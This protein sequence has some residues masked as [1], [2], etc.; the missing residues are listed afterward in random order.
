[1]FNIFLISNII[2]NISNIIALKKSFNR[3]PQKVTQNYH[4]PTIPFLGIYPK[5]LKTGTQ[6]HTCTCMFAAPLFTIV[7]TWTQS[8]CTSVAEW[9]KK[10][11]LCTYNG[12]LFSHKKHEVPIYAMYK[13]ESRQHYG[14]SKKPDTNYCMILFCMLP[15]I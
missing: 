12:I 8:N 10:I 14:K 2:Y 6:T 11:V 3:I 7:K 5:E 13:E 4:H 9:V 1:M 15:F